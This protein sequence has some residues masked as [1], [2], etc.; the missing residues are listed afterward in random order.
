[1]DQI[2]YIY[3]LIIWQ[4]LLFTIIL[5]SK[6][7]SK[8]YSNKFLALT[9]LTIGMHFTLIFFYGN[10]YVDIGNFTFPVYS[11]G[12]L[13]GPLIYMYVRFSLSKDVKFQAIELL[14]FLPFCGVLVVS[15]SATQVSSLIIFSR[16][17]IIFI[18]CMFG[19]HEVV[20]YR[21]TI[22]ATASKKWHYETNLLLL[23]LSITIYNSGASIVVNLMS[24]SSN[25]LFGNQFIP[26]LVLIGVLA[27]VNLI[28]YL[29][30]SKPHYFRQITKEDISILK[31]DQIKKPA[32]GAQ[33][34]TSL[35]L[36]LK[37]YMKKNKVY[38]NPDLDLT[39]LAEELE[40]HP[41][42]L[43]QSINRIIGSNFSDYVNSCRIEEAKELL[44]SNEDSDLTIKEVMYD[45]GFMSRSV[46]NTFFKKKTGMTPRE[47]RSKSDYPR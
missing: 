44:A 27:F 11:F 39:T 25:I 17:P 42:F 36:R 38:T 14:H 35:S 33:E 22:L 45:A 10:N 30:I 24:G 9:L 20:K 32:Y 16:L 13:Y 7:F 6:K 31:S 4:S 3:V 26:L 21:R 18:Y 19:I 12:F 40:V 15:N 23:L 29:G 5:F 28:V 43:S 8:K 47:Y 1:M 37:E 34:L 46:F 2:R 41:K